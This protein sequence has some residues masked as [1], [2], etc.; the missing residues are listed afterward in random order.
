[1]NKQEEMK[2]F[3]QLVRE[4]FKSDAE[5]AEKIYEGKG[6]EKEDEAY[7]IWFE[8]FADVTN[9]M[10]RRYNEN[11]VKNHF[12][13]FLFHFES[14]TNIIKECVDVSYVENLFWELDKKTCKHFW[15]LLPK[16]MQVLYLKFH[17]RKPQE[18]PHSNK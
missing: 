9:T 10:M 15:P 4:K 16:K 3:Y 18:P 6:W 5:Q 14:G 13:F 7:F 2:S 8:C 12:S 17:G 1:M 11:D